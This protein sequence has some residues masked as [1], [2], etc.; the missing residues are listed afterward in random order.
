LANFHAE[1]SG[2]DQFE[3]STEEIVP[4]T[5][6]EKKQK[7][8]E[9]RQKMTEKRAKRAVEEAQENKVNEAL[10]RKAG[11]DMNKIKEDMRLKEALKE[12]E[13]KKREKIED[14]KAKAAVKAQ[15]EADK[16]ARA[17]KAAREK[18]LRDGQPVIDSPSSTGPSRPAP[19]TTLPKK[20]FAETRLAIRMSS[21]GQQYTTTLPCDAPLRE[22]A[23]YLAG[24]LL[25][26]DVD[27]VSFTQHFPR[28][29][30]TRE[31]FSKS[32][33]DLGLTPSAVLI[34]TP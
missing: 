34:A 14:A 23:E 4:L 29:N 8:E 20:E 24:Q 7:L 5:E 31:D 12:A 28:K 3:E 25:S 6:E 2:H 32:L 11:K 21:G 10:R 26:V 33:K 15:I 16:K 1:K 22:V 17:E 30:F 27:T 13:V 9:L 19:A 18:A